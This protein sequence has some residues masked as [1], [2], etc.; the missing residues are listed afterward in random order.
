MVA[1][2]VILSAVVGAFVLEIGDQQET[3]PVSSITVDQESNMYVFGN[4]NTNIG[5]KTGV[6]WDGAAA[7][8]KLNDISFTHAGGDLLEKQNIRVRTS[9]G[10]KG[11]YALGAQNATEE[12]NGVTYPAR[13]TSSSD[14]VWNA[15]QIG[16][17]EQISSG[18]TATV[19]WYVSVQTIGTDMDNG[20]GGN[21]DNVARKLV[22]GAE[23][24]A[25]TSATTV[26]SSASDPHAA[27]DL[28]DPIH[29]GI[30]GIDKVGIP[31][32]TTCDIQD[33]E[34]PVHKYSRPAQEDSSAFGV[35]TTGDDVRVV[36]EASSGG[37]SQELRSYKIE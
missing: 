25:W 17:N 19:N 13:D 28:G 32:R 5:P 30:Q 27:S 15:K 10:G 22:N 1:I 35:L 24:C 7:H 29:F 8:A 37:K 6:P 26:A 20:P 9:A 14:A 34:G 21:G 12:A 2:A 16:A 36:W 3:A 11:S 33:G 31:D 4:D 18:D 23:V